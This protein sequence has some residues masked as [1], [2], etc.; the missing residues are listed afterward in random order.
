MTKK[1]H[2]T[3]AE[4]SSDSAQPSIPIPTH[5]HTERPLGLTAV[6][7]CNIFVGGI[8]GW[9]ALLSFG[10]LMNPAVDVKSDANPA[11]I[12][13]PAPQNG[14]DVKAKAKPTPSS[15][16]KST[17][18]AK[19][20]IST[21]QEPD[22]GQLLLVMIITGFIFLLATVSG[23]GCWKQKHFL[24]RRLATAFGVFGCIAIPVM[25]QIGGYGFT[26]VH[27]LFLLLCVANAS[28]VNTMFKDVFIN[29]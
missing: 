19:T 17:V 6:A 14:N 1:T 18:P 13:Q 26:W 2:Q 20:S 4:E 5:H 11:A 29:P 25:L 3:E 15:T 9:I 22:S 21:R 24:G 10:L 23:I 28:T 8:F 16:T 27:T 7:I 12:T